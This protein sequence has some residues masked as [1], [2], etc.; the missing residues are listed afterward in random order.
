ML[1]SCR[2][3]KVTLIPCRRALNIDLYFCRVVGSMWRSANQCSKVLGHG[4]LAV[5]RVEPPTGA[6]LAP[7]SLARA[8]AAFLDRQVSVLRRVWTGAW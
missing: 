2:S 1:R 5:E 8:R 3:P 6:D 4:D 7:S